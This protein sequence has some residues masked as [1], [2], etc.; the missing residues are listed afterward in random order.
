M[1]R[2]KSLDPAALNEYIEWL[3]ALRD[4]ELKDFF[5]AKEER[6]ALVESLKEYAHHNGSCVVWQDAT[7]CDCGLQELLT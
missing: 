4:D 6:E 7:E 2:P 3:T 5:E 1:N